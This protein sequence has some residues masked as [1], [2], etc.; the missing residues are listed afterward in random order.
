MA[1]AALARSAALR[2]A[3]TDDP[4]ERLLGWRAGGPAPLRWRLQD[5]DGGEAVE[6][7]VAPDGVRVGDGAQVSASA[8]LVAPDRIAVTLDGR[9]REWAYAQ[10]GDVTRI[11]LDGRAW[12]FA[13]EAALLR[14]GDRD[15]AG[16]LSA[17]MPGSVLLV[18][19]RDGD[20]VAVGDVL[21]VLESMKM[22]LQVVAPA[23]GTVAHV[24]VA[25]GDRVAGGQLLVELELELE[26]EIEL[27]TAA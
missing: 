16:S 10:D 25:P 14:A 7:L 23:S 4:W 13:E 21:V 15:E 9:R 3:A 22:E 12:G 6:V 17:P 18:H 20:R 26:R 2:A 24:A 1:A 5:E 19:A 11:G 27:G 8:E